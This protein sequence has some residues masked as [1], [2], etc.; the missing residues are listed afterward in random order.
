[1]ETMVHNSEG[2]MAGGEEKRVML[3]N[4]GIHKVSKPVQLVLDSFSKAFSTAKS[5]RWLSRR[6]QFFR[7][8]INIRFLQMSMPIPFEAN[9]SQL[10][11]DRFDLNSEVSLR[12]SAPFYRPAVKI[13]KLRE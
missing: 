12:V 8:K 3:M 13:W 5:S 11:N 4:Y 9:G 2:P 10:P 6:W 1:M 7:C